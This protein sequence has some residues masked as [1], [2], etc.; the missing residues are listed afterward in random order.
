MPRVSQCHARARSGIPPIEPLFNG[1][2]C[3]DGGSLDQFLDQAAHYMD[4]KGGA[5]VGERADAASVEAVP[6]IAVPRL[7]GARTAADLASAVTFDSVFLVSD[8]KVTSYSP[9]GKLNWHISTAAVWPTL[10]ERQSQRGKPQTRGRA[11]RKWR[12]RRSD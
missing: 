7:D 11:V 8:G 4:G 10:A 1:S 12:R 3:D 6:P 2:L 5:F 9:T